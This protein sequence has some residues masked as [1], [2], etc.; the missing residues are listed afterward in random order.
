MKVNFFEQD[1]ADDFFSAMNEMYPYAKE[2]R[3]TGGGAIDYVAAN[4]TDKRLGY[5][6]P[7]DGYYLIVRE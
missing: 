5:Y 3:H 2:S 1:S 4:K 7:D 6:I